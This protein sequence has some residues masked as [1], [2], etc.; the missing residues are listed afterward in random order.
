MNNQHRH[1]QQPSPQS[2]SDAT[3]ASEGAD[4][5]FQMYFRQSH[6]GISAQ[7]QPGRQV[8]PTRIAEE[9][10]GVFLL[11]AEIASILFGIGTDEENQVVNSKFPSANSSQST[12]PKPAAFGRLT[13]EAPSAAS[14]YSSSGPWH[15]DSS[16]DPGGQQ[17]PPSHDHAQPTLTIRN[18]QQA[19]LSKTDHGDAPARISNP[20]SSTSTRGTTGSSE[21]GKREKITQ[22]QT[23][24][25]ADSS[26]EN[27]LPAY[28]N[29]D[30]DDNFPIKFHQDHFNTFLSLPSSSPSPSS[31]SSSN[32]NNNNHHHLENHF[33]AEYNL[34]SS[35]TAARHTR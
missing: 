3:G 33:P 27:S 15:P 17:Q 11:D 5:H 21:N 18:I 28:S 34:Y 10:V 20:G 8:P 9:A 2:D 31:I 13:R 6:D 22:T 35:T 16:Q 12:D 30:P 4:Y 24:L 25:D 23:G 32:K 26:K 19:R 29:S 7:H 14:E 1:Q